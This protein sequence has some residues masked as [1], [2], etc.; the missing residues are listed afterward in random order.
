[1]GKKTFAVET[2]LDRLGGGWHGGPMLSP[3]GLNK[4]ETRMFTAHLVHVVTPTQY[5]S[6]YE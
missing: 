3:L 5:T 4:R 6:L 2:A 1:M